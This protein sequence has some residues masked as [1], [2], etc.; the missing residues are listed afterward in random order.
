M[1]LDPL[2]EVGFPLQLDN[3]G[4]VADPDYEAHVRQMIELVLF[5]SPGERVNRPTF[6]C[7]LLELI[8]APE[9]EP[10]ASATGYLIQG[11]L[12]KWLGEVISVKAVDVEPRDGSLRIRVEY[13]LL[14]DQETRTATFEPPRELWQL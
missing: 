11:A 10:E 9:S 14:R 1:K 8:F 12:Q 4:R 7:G 5:T 2:L 6:G 3:R 13:L